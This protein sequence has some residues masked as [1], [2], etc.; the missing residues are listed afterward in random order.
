MKATAPSGTVPAR[1]VALPPYKPFPVAV[2]PRSLAAFVGKGAAALG[3]DAAMVALPA[4]AACGAIIGNTRTVRLKNKWREPSVFWT[5]VVADSG[6]LKSPALDLAV[7]PLHNLQK[8]LRVEHAARLTEYLALHEEWK[9]RKGRDAASA[10][11]EP[12]KPILPRV[13]CSDT[14]IERLGEL[15]SENTRGILNA[16]DEQAGWF[17]SFARYKSKGGASDLP[18]WLEFFRAGP[19]TIDRKTS[20]KKTLF[21]D[22]AAVSVTGTI[23]PGILAKLVQGDFLDSGLIARLLLAMPPKARKQ[24]RETDLDSAT[25]DAYE[26]LL[27]NSI[28]WISAR[29]AKASACPPPC[30]STP[31]R[32]ERGLT[33]TTNGA[34]NN[35]IR[36]ANEVPPYR[37]WKATP[38]G[39]LYC[40]MFANT[41]P[42][43]WMTGCLSGSNPLRLALR[44][45]G[46][47]PAR[48]SAST[49]Y[50]ARLPS[51]GRRAGLS[52][53]SRGAAV[54]SRPA[55]CI[56]AT[57]GSIRLLLPPNWPSTPWL[58]PALVNGLSK[59]RPVADAPRKSSAST[60]LPVMV[61]RYR[62]RP[63]HRHRFHRNRHRLSRQ[64]HS[65]ANR[66][67]EFNTGRNCPPARN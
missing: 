45:A 4:I 49:R 23:Q 36:K 35:L 58:V 14:T 64:P 63:R 11:P 39:S 2:L 30:P 22:R 65:E 6:T 9:A 18:A 3:C 34:E 60:A 43:D 41:S 42:P 25:A 51:N 62:N 17:G 16:R 15:L 55:S 7:N 44:S 57:A 8:C 38:R 40:I 26:Q 28:G 47:L 59:R 1:P 10:G 67:C 53:I 21:I 50:S 54:P 19:V 20:E 61:H 37:N 5:C 46:G 66:A 33:S 48:R 29:T 12:E 24:W 32:G 56:V 13:V 27:G 52:S 31:P